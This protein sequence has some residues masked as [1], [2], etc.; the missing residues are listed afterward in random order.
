[1]KQTHYFYSTLIIGLSMFLVM[2]CEEDA[3]NYGEDEQGKV[4]LALTEV[5]AEVLCIRIKATR[6]E[7]VRVKKFDVAAGDDTIELEMGR[8]P[9]GFTTFE[10]WAYDQSC[11][12]LA[13]AQLTH[14]ADSADAELAPGVVTDVTLAFRKNNSVDV[15][16]DF[17]KNVKQVE[18]GIYQNVLVFEDGTARHFG[19]NSWASNLPTDIAKLSLKWG[20]ACAIKKDGSLWCWG[21]NYEG[22]VGNGTTTN[23][24]V[25]VELMAG[26][27]FIDV[28]VGMQFSCAVTSSGM[29]Y[30]WGSND[31]GQLGIGSN[32]DVTTPTRVD[33]LSNVSHIYAGSRHTCA[34][35]AH[36]VRCWGRN[37]YGQIGNNTTENANTPQQVVGIGAVKSLALGSSHSCAALADGTVQCW[38]Y[39][40]NG[41][42]GDGTNLSASSP[43]TL[44]GISGVT[45]ITAGSSHT[46]GRLDD[47]SVRCWGYNRWGQIGNNS[48]EDVTT[49]TE[50]LLGATSVHAGNS[51]GCARMEDQSIKCWGSNSH[52]QLGDDSLETHWTPTDF[53]S[54]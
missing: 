11:A 42:L 39:N 18:M 29:P 36:G 27:T 15:S 37:N 13:G 33:Y 19:W 3:E 14:V 5:P 31:Y 20:H 43:V 34:M 40:F 53:V 2:A 26:T 48:N 7:T 45:H 9:L 49:P 30:C 24:A 25:A 10:G 50:I 6:D 35:Q 4:V 41:Q 23:T 12:S 52:G 47:S 21:D 22:Q 38:G 44:S 1:M 28:S 46:C 32:D 8:L 54:W 17:L 16:A 51:N